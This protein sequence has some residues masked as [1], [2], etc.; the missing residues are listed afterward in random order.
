MALTLKPETSDKPR[1]P[2]MLHCPHT[3]REKSNTTFLGASYKER[4]SSV[5][6]WLEKVPGP[7]VKASL[8]EYSVLLPA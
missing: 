4:V 2:S 6:K 1:K 8:S 7:L 3:E 5:C